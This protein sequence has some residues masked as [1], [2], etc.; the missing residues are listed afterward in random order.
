MSR[1][2]PST[3]CNGVGDVMVTWWSPSAVT[4]HCLMMLETFEA[5]IGFSACVNVKSTSWAVNGRP[6]WN[7]TS[8]R[9][10]STAVRP[11]SEKSQ[12]RA[13]SGFGSAMVDVDTVINGSKI[14]RT[15]SRLVA[16]WVRIRFVWG[17]E[18]DAAT[19]V[20][21]GLQSAAAA[22]PFARASACWTADVQPAASSAVV[23]I[24]TTASRRGRTPVDMLM[25]DGLLGE[26][27]GPRRE[28]AGRWSRHMRGDPPP[29]AAGHRSGANLP[30]TR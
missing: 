11:P 15:H 9:R 22:A 2:L 3:G 5:L 18:D 23:A 24:A 8:S 28:T 6:D 27:S 29:G 26:F 1:V 21:P 20:P 10:C 19:S 17:A 16:C 14:A 30:S 13:S 12:E 4:V 7:F 25:V